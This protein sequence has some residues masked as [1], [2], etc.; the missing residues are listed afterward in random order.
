MCFN[1]SVNISILNDSSLKL[2]DKFT[3]RVSSVSSTET[4]INTRL[5]KAWT[6]IDILSVIRK[7]DPTDKI[8]FSF[9]QAAVMSILLYGCTR[10]TLTRRMVKRPNGNYTRMLRAKL[11]KSWRQHPPKQQ[12]YGNLPP[13][14]KI[15]LDEPD[16]GTL[17]ENKDEVIRDVVLWPSLHGRAKAE[18]TRTYIQQ[19]CADTECSPEH[20]PEGMDD[21]EGRRE[22]LRDIRAHG[23]TS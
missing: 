9:F 20:L 21:R 16:G 6:A 11:N 5:E 17:L 19:L 14:T 4:N 22:R 7:S 23:M 15:K 18:Q 2:V 3:Y 12:L 8:K 13:I 1:Q 10:W